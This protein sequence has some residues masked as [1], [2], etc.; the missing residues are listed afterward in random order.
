MHLY[1]LA[2]QES[3]DS[4][5]VV[6]KVAGGATGPLLNSEAQLGQHVLQKGQY[7]S[8]PSDIKSGAT[9]GQGYLEA[10][11]LVC[12]LCDSTTITLHRFAAETL[13]PAS[14]GPKRHHVLVQ[15][16]PGNRSISAKVHSKPTAK[17]FIL[18]QC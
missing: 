10:I 3:C 1:D 11:W 4:Q 2:W 17:L 12:W 8:D 6:T 16:F 7:Y 9:Q 13:P 14:M 5:C 18:P 15:H